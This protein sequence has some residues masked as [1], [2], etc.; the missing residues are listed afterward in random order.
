MGGQTVDNGV[1][2]VSFTAICSIQALH[3]ANNKINDT[4]HTTGQYHHLSAHA[5]L[6]VYNK[7]VNQ[8]ITA[9]SQRIVHPCS[10][11][12]SCQLPTAWDTNHSLLKGDNVSRESRCNTVTN[13]L[14]TT[15]E[16][17]IPITFRHIKTNYINGIIYSE[18]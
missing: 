15:R 6:F 14:G 4:R 3:I 7:F 12:H 13:N 17:N 1:T 10:V 11:S 9:C 18:V 16:L 2:N 5:I 8:A